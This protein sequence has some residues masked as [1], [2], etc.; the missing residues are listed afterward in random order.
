MMMIITRGGSTTIDPHLSL[1]DDHDGT[2]KSIHYIAV[3]SHF[4][5]VFIS[6]EIKE[7]RQHE[8]R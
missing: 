1:C 6:T 7:T 3:W 8:A 2:K 4:L 5:L